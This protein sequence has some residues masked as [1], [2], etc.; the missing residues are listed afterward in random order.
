[1]GFET[2]AVG[3]HVG[4]SLASA[5][6]SVAVVNPVDVIRTRLF[7]QP[8]GPDGR[9]LW[10]KSGFDAGAKVVSVEGPLA[11]YK[12][13]GSNFLRLGPHMVFVFVILE[14]FKKIAAQ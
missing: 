2:G 8:Y 14:Q 12:G 11:L 9:G 13:A 3:T 5:A 7:N 1:M 10:Y 6:V 4:C